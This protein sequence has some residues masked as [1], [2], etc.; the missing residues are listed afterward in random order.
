MINGL[1][2][3]NCINFGFLGL[4][5]P[6]VQQAFEE[7]QTAELDLE[8]WTISNAETGALLHATPIPEQLLN[9][10]QAG[11][12]YPDLEREGFISS[13]NLG[14]RPESVA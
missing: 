11:G 5:C 6:G 3:R 8:K 1:F 2:F 12:V 4:E 10:V 9:L 13:Y 14:A 7:G